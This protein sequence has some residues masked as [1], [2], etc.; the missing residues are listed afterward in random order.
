[1]KTIGQV[2]IP[3]KNLER[4]VSFYRDLLKLPLLFETDTMAFFH[5]GDTRLLL[6]LPEKEEFAQAS[7][8]LYFRVEHLRKEYEALIEKGVTFTT[9]P[10]FVAKMGRTET[11]MAFFSG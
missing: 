8:I 2:S 7:S 3:V 10:H 11:W 5:C 1:M 4:A 9:E 6:G